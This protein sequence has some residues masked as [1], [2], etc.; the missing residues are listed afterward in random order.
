MTTHPTQPIPDAACPAGWVEGG[1][2]GPPP[3]GA[4]KL[5]LGEWGRLDQ[6]LRWFRWVLPFQACCCRCCRRRRRRRCRSRCRC[7]CCCCSHA[8]GCCTDTRLLY[9]PC[10]HACMCNPPTGSHAHAVRCLPLAARGLQLTLRPSWSSLRG[11]R[12]RSAL[13]CMGGCCGWAAV[14]WDRR[15]RAAL[16]MVRQHT[17]HKDGCDASGV[18]HPR[19]A[20]AAQDHHSGGAGQPGHRQPRHGRSARCGRAGQGARAAGEQCCRMSSLL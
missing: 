5:D 3:L 18:C 20:A 14:G 9:F 6:L 19:C 2:G 1:A 16:H 13:A 10:G 4:S 12:R 11:S 7:C 15:L 17:V 8:C